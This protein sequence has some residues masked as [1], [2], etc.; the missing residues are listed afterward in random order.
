M[1]IWEVGEKQG[2]PPGRLLIIYLGVFNQM[3]TSTFP[4][5]PEPVL[6]VEK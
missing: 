2:S 6:F 5:S 3:M 4:S 1:K